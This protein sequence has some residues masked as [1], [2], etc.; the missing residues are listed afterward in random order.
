MLVPEPVPDDELSESGSMESSD[1]A[2]PW[3]STSNGA[4]PM[5]TEGPGL[6]SPPRD[7]YVVGGEASRDISQQAVNQQAPSS[8]SFVS[9]VAPS[10]P[11]PSNPPSAADWNAYRPIFTEHYITEGKT[12]KDTMQ[13]MAE[14]YGFEAT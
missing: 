10:L 9:T 7:T 8:Q 1:S 2:D 13:I 11:V 4:T 5:S 3:A 14:R 6:R 12:L